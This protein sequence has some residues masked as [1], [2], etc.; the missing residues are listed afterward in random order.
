MPPR[1]GGGAA[2]EVVGRC[3]EGSFE[4]AD[5]VPIEFMRR[6]WVAHAVLLPLT[7]PIWA[8]GTAAGCAGGRTGG[9]G[10]RLNFNSGVSGV[11]YA[12]FGAEYAVSVCVNGLQWV[13]STPNFRTLARRSRRESDSN[14]RERRFRWNSTSLL[15]FPAAPA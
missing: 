10:T 1:G 9:R 2:G 11:N 14:S 13:S 8:P 15:K 4:R 5:G 6:C 3:V 12:G 7:N